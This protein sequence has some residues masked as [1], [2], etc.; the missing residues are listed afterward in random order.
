MEKFLVTGHSGFIKNE[1]FQTIKIQFEALGLV[2]I[3]YSQTT[4]GSMGLFW[5]LTQNGK[6]M[7]V[8]I[9]AIREA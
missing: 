5:N 9:R 6:N 2:K 7:V 3:L 8:D 4:K 1:D